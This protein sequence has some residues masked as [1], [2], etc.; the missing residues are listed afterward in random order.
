MG[1]K[2]DASSFCKGIMCG[3]ECC[4]VFVRIKSCEYSGV[5]RSAM[6]PGIYVPVLNWNWQPEK[7]QVG[8]QDECLNLYSQKYM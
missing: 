4:S 7:G 6:S 2:V 3:K 1:A 5:G 8:V